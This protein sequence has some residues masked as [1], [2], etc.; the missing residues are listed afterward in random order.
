MAKP[1]VNDALLLCKLSLNLAHQLVLPYALLDHFLL[2]IKDDEDLA[3]KYNKIVLEES[4]LLSFSMRCQTHYGW[5][6]LHFVEFL[7]YLVVVDDP[8]NTW[9]VGSESVFLRVNLH[10][11]L[12]LSS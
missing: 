11:H 3:L 1:R 6:E 12:F 7:D 9:L 10:S 4:Y 8:H 5:R 2:K